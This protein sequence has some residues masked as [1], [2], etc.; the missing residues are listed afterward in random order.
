MY[1]L[2]LNLFNLIEVF[3]LQ[4]KYHLCHL[5]IIWNILRVIWKD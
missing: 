5:S 2:L 1:V 3:F 4:K